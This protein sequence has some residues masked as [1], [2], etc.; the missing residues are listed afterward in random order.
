MNKRQRKRK[1]QR[2]NAADLAPLVAEGYTEDASAEEAFQEAEHKRPLGD[3]GSKGK[4]AHLR[5]VD[6]RLEQNRGGFAGFVASNDA[7]AVWTDGVTDRVQYDL[8]K[9]Y[10]PGGMRLLR[11]GRQCLRCDEPLDPAFPVKCPLCG[12]S[13]KDRQV[14]DIAMEFEGEKHLGP[15]R[16]ITEYM[17]EQ[18]ARVEKRKFIRRVLEGGQGKVPKEWL[19]DATLIEDLTPQERFAIGVRAE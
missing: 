9:N 13:V 6:A 1:Q 19:R 11:E 16:P 18:D 2:I 8:H 7:G 12:Y 14:M 17:E 5:D 4:L 10:T 3:V 15:S